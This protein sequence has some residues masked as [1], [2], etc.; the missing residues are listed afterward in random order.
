MEL[1]KRGKF[2]FHSNHWKYVSKEGRDFISR[3]LKVNPKKRMSADEALNHPWI[4]KH[5]T[6]EKTKEEL[7]D[8]TTSSQ[9]RTKQRTARRSMFRW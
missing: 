7:A 2:T 4:V 6:T 8:K 5:A 1:I 9:S 3:L